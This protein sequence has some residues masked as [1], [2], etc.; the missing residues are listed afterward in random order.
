MW[1]KAV[2]KTLHRFRDVDV[3]DLSLVTITGSHA[4]DMEAMRVEVRRMRRSLRDLR[5]AQAER[6]PWWRDV[7]I[8][9][10]ADLMPAGDHGAFLVQPVARLLVHHPRVP[11][12]SVERVMRDWFAGSGRDVD[13]GR[14]RED[15]FWGLPPGVGLPMPWRAAVVAT[16]FVWHRG[17]EPLRVAVGAQGSGIGRVVGDV[18]RGQGTAPIR[19]PMP[20]AF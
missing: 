19:E 14:Y 20:I 6:R 5:D 3:A 17:M 9:G 7:R 12:S 2:S 18:S 1:R 13:V 10:L 16:L 4:K 8:A 11:R 15:A